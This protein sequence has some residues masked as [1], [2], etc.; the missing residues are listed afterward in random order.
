MGK[1]RD[2]YPNQIGV[3]IGEITLTS[4]PYNKMY[5]GK[6]RKVIDYQCICGKKGTCYFSI[7]YQNM[8]KS[9][10]CIYKY[11]D[12]L[13]YSKIKIC[14]QSMHKR[15]KDE[16]EGYYKWYKDKGVSVCERWRKFENFY[17]DMN[18]SWF[19][20]AQLD[21]Y[22]NKNGNYEPGNVR[23]AT[24]KEQQRNKISTKLTEEKVAFIRKSSL[25]QN[26]LAKM[27]NVGQ[28]QISK[29]KNY[30]QWL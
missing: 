8:P 14:F 29:I 12:R 6:V 11:Q 17:N 13:K 30:K 1:K 23:W 28:W 21:R 16:T 25:S 5:G 3:L 18:E 27:F 4:Q 7:S 19:L 10:G 9:C 26:K 15:C 22:P 2:I 24:I 20:G